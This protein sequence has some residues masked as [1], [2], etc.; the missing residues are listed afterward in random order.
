VA[1]SAADMAAGTT[2]SAPTDTT[3]HFNL[4]IR[5]MYGSIQ[6]VF[7]VKGSHFCCVSSKHT[8]VH[9]PHVCRQ[10]VPTYC[11]YAQILCTNSMHNHCA[12]AVCFDVEYIDDCETNYSGVCTWK[13]LH[14]ESLWLP[15][16]HLYHS[17]TRLFLCS[18]HRP[19]THAA[20]ST[21]HHPNKLHS[22]QALIM[23]H[24]RPHTQHAVHKA[25]R[26]SFFWMSQEAIGSFRKSTLAQ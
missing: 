26:T 4:G 25:A 3:Q 19:S 16:H 13:L 24:Q 18:K 22:M 8:C 6:H 9:P 15:L 23:Q 20:C 14:R 2:P 17:L 12:L 21:A 11:P 1:S 10:T 5:K 7:M